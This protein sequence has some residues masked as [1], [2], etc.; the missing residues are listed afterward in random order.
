[1]SDKKNQAE[2][3]SRVHVGPY[4]LQ[5]TLPKSKVYSSPVSLFS[6]VFFTPYK[7]NFLKV[8]AISSVPMDST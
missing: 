6:I 4:E 8:E 1:M 5:S 7:S 3:T 2:A